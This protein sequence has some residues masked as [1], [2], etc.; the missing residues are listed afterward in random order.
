LTGPIALFDI[1]IVEYLLWRP[2]SFGGKSTGW[3]ITKRGDYEYQ[4]ENFHPSL[5]PNPK[6]SVLYGEDG[7]GDFNNATTL[8]GIY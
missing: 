5:Q 1:N 4:P 6:F 7:T 2:F 3:G 8:S